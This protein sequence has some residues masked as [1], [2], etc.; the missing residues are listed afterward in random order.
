VA[1][2]LVVLGFKPEETHPNAHTLSRDTKVIN[3][4][5]LVETVVITELTKRKREER[6]KPAV[7]EIMA[8]AWGKSALWGSTF[9]Q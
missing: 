3:S 8:A 1:K 6:R 2:L 4:R 9:V 7:E 5:Y